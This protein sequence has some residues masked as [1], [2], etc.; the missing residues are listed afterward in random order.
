MLCRK[1]LYVD[2]EQKALVTLLEEDCVEKFEAIV[3]GLNKQEI[4]RSPLP[5]LHMRV[6][7]DT[8]IIAHIHYLGV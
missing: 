7:D 6:S 5:K 8:D 2:D 3:Q 4:R 1:G